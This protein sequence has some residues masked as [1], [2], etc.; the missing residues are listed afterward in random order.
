MPHKEHALGWPSVTQILGNYDLAW[1]PFFY[2]KWGTYEAATAYSTQ[3]KERG[4]RIHSAFELM[5]QGKDI[6]L[7]MEQVHENE[8]KAVAGLQG[9]I[10]GAEVMSLNEEREVEC[11]RK[12]YHGSMDHE[13]NILRTDWV[14]TDFWRNMVPNENPLHCIGDLKTQ[15]DREVKGSEI[16]KHAMQLAAYSY[17]LEEETGKFINTGVIINVDIA[18]GLVSPVV[19]HPLAAYLEPFFMLRDLH[20]YIKSDGKWGHLRLRK[21]AA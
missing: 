12:A 1:L 8:R 7:C 10:Q 16:K 3:A 5:L 14:K 11:K 17:A 18:T 9:W 6:S 19:I 20:D 2:K 15:D 4:T 21:K 13:L